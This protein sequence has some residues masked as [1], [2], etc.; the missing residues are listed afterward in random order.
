[1]TLVLETP[2]RNQNT[3]GS[4]T[5]LRSLHNFVVESIF[6]I[7]FMVSHVELLLFNNTITFWKADARSY[8]SSVAP[9]YL[10]IVLGT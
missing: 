4:F 9:T 8:S 6:F 3:L 2:Q 5:L 7:S 10:S 1:M